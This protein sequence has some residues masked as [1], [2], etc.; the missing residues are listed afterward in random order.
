MRPWLRAVITGGLAVGVGLAAG[1]AVAAVL[2]VTAPVNAVGSSVIDRTPAWLREWAIDVFGT[3]DKV[4]LQ[5]IIVVIVVALSMVVAR[6]AMRRRWVAYVGAG[7]MTVVAIVAADTTTDG[8]SAWIP[9]VVAGAVA[10][11]VL[12]ALTPVPSPVET[13]GESETVGTADSFDR[14]DF[15]LRAAVVAAAGAGAAATGALVTGARTREVAAGA[16]SI[17]LPATADLAP[18]VPASASI[19][20]GVEPFI[21]P[22]DEFYRIDTALAVPRV[23]LDDWRLTIDGMVDRPLSL[24]F[25]EL[26]E[27]R[28]VE[29][30]VTLACVS[31]EVGGPYISNAT[32][33]GVPLADLLEEVGVDPDADQL[34]SYSVDG[35][36]CGF[37]TEVALDGRDALVAVGM[38]GEPLPPLH[39]FPVRLVVP[40]L[41]GYVSATKWLERIEL[42]T[43][44]AFD[45]YW[46]PRGW[47]K[48]APIKLQ[49][50]IDVPKN[51]AA[52]A[53]GPIAV[54]GIAWAQPIGV[55]GVEV[56]VDEGEWEPAT[57]ATDVTADAWRQWF[58]EWD[59][60][61]GEHRLEVRA[62]DAD[63]L[64][65][66][67]EPARPAPDGAQ[68]WDTVTL[69]VD[70]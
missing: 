9:A 38:N 66:T 54:A 39:G 51:G 22:N 44:D 15:A 35:W 30:I 64:V 26:L 21:T 27:R 5:L 65:Q 52:I 4:V 16:D 24:D 29:R 37:P 42:T 40:G 11:V 56:R 55:G 47:A 58:F 36:N 7:A 31:N 48:E 62:I 41:Y 1:W 43:L 69:R 60:T 23:N 53:P 8:S 67:G 59:A 49:S 12:L 3:A 14:R 25:D 45:G 57:L 63:G 2:G 70:G 20:H 10:L 46:I 17:V 19:G 28:V 32:W 33:L 50:R 18:P 13:A 68:G 6:L 34:A 61:S